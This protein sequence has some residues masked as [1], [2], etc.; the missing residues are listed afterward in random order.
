[1][2]ARAAWRLET[3]GFHRVYRYEPGKADWSANGLPMEGWT[4]GSPKA[5]DIVRPDVPLCKLDETIGNVRGRTRQ[6]GWDVCVVVDGDRVVLGR[7]RKEAFAAP[8]EAT[9][10]DL[11]ES[12]PT[13]IRPDVRLESILERLRQR[14]VDKILVTTTDGQLI[15]VLF[16]DDAERH[17]TTKGVGAYEE[18]VCE[19]DG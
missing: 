14:N 13:T 5:G 10:E 12:G 8:P 2:S 15:G 9:V 18:E 11:M 1:M 4:A 16:R 3:L 6:E 17:I 19:C 7:L